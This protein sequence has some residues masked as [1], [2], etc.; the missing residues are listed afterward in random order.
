MMK[1]LAITIAVVLLV[2]AGRQAPAAEVKGAHQ[3]ANVPQRVTLVETATVG[4]NSIYLGDLFIGTGD[5][6]GTPVAYAPKPGRKAAFDARWLYRVARAYGL[7]WRPLSLRDRVV[8]IRDSIVIGPDQIR[9]QILEALSDYGIGAGMEVQLSNRLMRIHVSGDAAPTLEVEDIIYNA[10][11]RRFTAILTA[12][13]GDPSASRYR[14][15]GR[16]YE[17]QEAPVLVRRKQA[18]QIIGPEDVKWT[19]IRTEQ[20]QR[21]V[22]LEEGGLIGMAARR[23]LRAGV[24]VRTTDVRRPVL[25]P[26]GSLV[27]L[28][29]DSP[30]MKLTAQGRAMEDG[31]DGQAIRITNTQ[32]NTIIQGVVT[33][34]N[35]VT[36]RTASNVVMN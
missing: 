14:V 33:G 6:A 23:G 18:G 28:I 26:K 8:V 17:I 7:N 12:P 25:V 15:T 36:V 22:I 29:L 34:A 27:T 35:R 1:A 11:A 21:N 20:L 32:S 19:K 9:A 30:N 3:V 4:G 24:P 16:L 2:S 31:S 10:R 13:A 5:K